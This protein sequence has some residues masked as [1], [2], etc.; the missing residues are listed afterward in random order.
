MQFAQLS[1][2]L[3]ITNADIFVGDFSYLEGGYGDDELN[4]RDFDHGYNTST[5][6]GG[7]GN[8]TLN[9]NNRNDVLY[10]GDGN[11]VLNGGLGD[12][13]LDGGNGRDTLTGGDGV[14]EFYFDSPSEGID[15][16]TDFS[17]ADDTIHVSGNGFGSGLTLRC[18][19]NFGTIHTR[20]SSG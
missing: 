2:G 1:T 6:D 9:G 5:L 13:F 12:D 17:V 19:C 15:N 8:D 18:C 10:G 3:A 4:G 20:I 7:Y 11:D 16:I 14:D